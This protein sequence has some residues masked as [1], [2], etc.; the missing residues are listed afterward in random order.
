MIWAPPG[1]CHAPPCPPNADHAPRLQVP[2]LRPA[3]YSSARLSKSKKTVHRAYG[4]VLSGGAVRDRVVRAFL[5]DEQKIV[6]K[7]LR[8]GSQLVGPGVAVPRVTPRP[9]RDLL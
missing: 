8:C 4:G 9:S 2:R 3:Q 7:V 5:V 1:P 6:K